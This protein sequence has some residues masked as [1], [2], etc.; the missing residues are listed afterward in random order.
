MKRIILFFLVLFPLLAVAQTQSYK[1]GYGVDQSKFTNQ[2]IANLAPGA[3]WYYDWSHSTYLDFE[4]AN[5]DFVPM[6]W[7]GGY[8]A[9]QLRQFLSEH[10]NVKYLLAFNE[11]NFRDQANMTPSQ[12]AAAWPALQAIA[13]EYTRSSLLRRTG[14]AGALKRVARPTTRPMIGCATSLLPVPNA[15]L[16]I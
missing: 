2:A 13:D 6:T 7:N 16:I 14:A 1:R 11:P 10:P 9:S 5:V 3:G 4:G 12:A 8:N 15:A